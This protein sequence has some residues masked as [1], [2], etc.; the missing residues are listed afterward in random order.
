MCK[1]EHSIALEFRK[2]R[3]VKG[4]QGRP[5]RQREQLAQWLSGSVPAS[6]DPEKTSSP[7]Q[8]EQGGKWKEIRLD[9]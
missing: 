2:E 5:P 8:T 7:G 4:R 3:E 9:Q 1:K 6:Q